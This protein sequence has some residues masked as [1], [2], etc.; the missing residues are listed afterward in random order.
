M[1]TSAV[2]IMQNNGC[3]Q[4]TL[5]HKHLR[6]P[7][8]TSPSFHCDLPGVKSVFSHLNYYNSLL[9]ASQPSFF[10]PRIHFHSKFQKHRTELVTFLLSKQKEEKT[11][12]STHWL[13]DQVHSLGPG[14]QGPSSRK[15]SSPWLLGAVS[16]LEYPPF[17]PSG[18]KLL[19][20]L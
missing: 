8:P 19:L 7:A 16:C 4:Q 18:S 5:L 20:I 6:T 1:N 3:L 13:Q 9:M 10:P 17:F 14:I 12:T 2:S 15:Q 11:L